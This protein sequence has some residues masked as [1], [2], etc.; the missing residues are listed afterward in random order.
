MRVKAWAELYQDGTSV[1]QPMTLVAANPESGSILLDGYENT[2]NRA[3]AKLFSLHL[4]VFY[5]ARIDETWE[6]Y[7]MTRKN[8]Q[9]SIQD[10][11]V[12]FAQ[13]LRETAF[14]MPT[15]PI[16]REAFSAWEEKVKGYFS[17]GASNFAILDFYAFPDISFAELFHRV[18]HLEEKEAPGKQE[19]PTGLLAVLR[20]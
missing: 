6:Q 3:P 15:E 5:T 18:F 10:N 2:W 17:H 19:Y 7:L 14:S 8:F 16:D 11:L 1:P 9:Q 12:H 4:P 20:P 13:F